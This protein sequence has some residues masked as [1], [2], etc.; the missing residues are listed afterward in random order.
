MAEIS[1]LRT[2]LG[3]SATEYK[4]VKNTL[5]KIASKDTSV[6][7]A[8]EAFSGPVAVALGYNDPVSAPKGLLEFSKANNKLKVICGVVDGRLCSA[9]EIK[10][11]AE[12]PPKEVLLSMLAG[13]MTAPLRKLG[14]GL[15]ATNARLAYALSA[16]KAKK[17]A[18]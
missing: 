7:A 8:K 12:L 1:D 15:S 5:A 4:V 16:L 6:E 9:K 14:Y 13:V 18:A 10:A 3:G 2:K 17:E 11:V